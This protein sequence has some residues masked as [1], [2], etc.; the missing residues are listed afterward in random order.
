MDP[1]FKKMNYKEQK[2]VCVINAPKSFKP[3]LDAIKSTAKVIRNLGKVD[4]IDFI[5]VFATEKSQIDDITPKIADNLDGDG[6][7]WFAYPKGTSKNYKCD[8]NRDTGWKTLGEFGFEGVRMVAVDED[9][10]ALR[11]RK[12]EYIKKLRRRKSMTLSK[13]GKERTKGS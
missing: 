7:V 12:V 1:I 6:L 11:F 10:S 5:L 2:E 4:K 9:W 8:F 3:N 13:A